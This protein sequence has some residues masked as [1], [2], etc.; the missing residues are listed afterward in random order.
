MK[1]KKVA[2]RVDGGIKIGLGHIMRSLALAKTFTENTRI[3]FI[4]QENNIVRSLLDNCRFKKIYIDDKL[5]Y[6]EEI[7]LVKKMILENNFDI[8]ITDSYDLDQNYL[9]QI[10]KIVDKL[11]TIHDFAPF[12]FPSDIVINGNIYASDLDY[13]SLNDNTKFL[14][15]TDYTLMR[16]EFQNLPKRKI[17]QDVNNILVT[18]GGSDKLNLTPKIL[19]G[20][21]QLDKKKL[22][23]DVVVGSGFDNVYG[24]IN[25]VHKSNFEI[26][27]IFNLNKMSE[28][29]LKSDLAISAGGTTLYELATTGTPTITLIQADNQVLV[30]EAMEEKGAIINLG[31]G[32]QISIKKIITKVQNLINDYDRRVSMSQAGQKIVDGKGVIRVKKE[33]LCQ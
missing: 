12:S 17:N 11:V 1:I 22:K 15:G 3:S 21:N 9:I 26:N 30:A 29:M 10:K 25:E 31:F 27:L 13:Q 7:K 19:R 18:V 32:D 24:I 2:F 5:E 20:I 8:V 16:E 4:T 33:I 23:V 14:L 28:L 6:E